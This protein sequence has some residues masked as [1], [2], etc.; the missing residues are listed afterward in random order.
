MRGARL[1]WRKGAAAA[2]DW[3]LTLVYRAGETD[4]LEQESNLKLM[5]AQQSVPKRRTELWRNM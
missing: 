4:T 1:R 3:A 2:N 5:A